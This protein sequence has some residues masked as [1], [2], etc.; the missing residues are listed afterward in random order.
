MTLVLQIYLVADTCDDDNINFTAWGTIISLLVTY[1]SAMIKFRVYREDPFW[2]FVFV[3]AATLV[4][5]FNSY[6]AGRISHDD[7]CSGDEAVIYTSLVGYSLIIPISHAFK[8][9][10]KRS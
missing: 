5:L 8:R 6:Q 3:G 10:K 2:T 4:L 7:I 1:F 9:D